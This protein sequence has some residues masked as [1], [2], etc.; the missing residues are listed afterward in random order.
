MDQ[1][2]IDRVDFDILYKNSLLLEQL[3][4]LI[5][6]NRQSETFEIQYMD[7]VLLPKLKERLIEWCGINEMEQL[8]VQLDKL[9]QTVKLGKIEQHDNKTT[10]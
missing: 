2:T 9:I 4:K 6:Y 5:Y 3:S 7:T 1:V 10:G 8:K